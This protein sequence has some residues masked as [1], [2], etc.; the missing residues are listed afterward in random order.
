LTYAAWRNPKSGFDKTGEP[1]LFYR[2]GE[3]PTAIDPEFETAPDAQKVQS[4]REL[5]TVLRAVGP[6]LARAKLPFALTAYISEHGGQLLL[7]LIPLLSILLP[8]MRFAP[9]LYNWTI[10]RRLLVW[11][12]RLKIV[13][14]SII[15]ADTPEAL[16][17]ARTALENIDRGVT[18]IRVP[19]A[20]SSQLYDLR[21][22]YNVVRNRLETHP[23]A[24][25]L[26]AAA[27]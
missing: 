3:L 13:E 16:A 7:L 20:F 24:R 2:T 21:M 23:L 1:I 26:S 10:R 14:Q 5:P 27:A 25:T 8:T 12:R 15:K 4:T 18:Q 9:I 19:L 22:H 6:P 17:A 11:Y